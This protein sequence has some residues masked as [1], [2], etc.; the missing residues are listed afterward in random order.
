MVPA[1]P[2]SRFVVNL[3]AKREMAALLEHSHAV[4]LVEARHGVAI[5]ADPRSR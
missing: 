1:M 3:E 2:V 5:V 4:V